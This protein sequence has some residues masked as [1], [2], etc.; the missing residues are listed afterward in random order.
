MCWADYWNLTFPTSEMAGRGQWKSIWYGVMQAS[1]AGGAIALGLLSQNATVIVGVAITS[2]FMPPITNTG[3]L[4]AWVCHISWRGLGQDYQAY[5]YTG[6]IYM[7]KPA[8]APYQGYTPLYYPDMRWECMYMSYISAIYTYVNV[9]CLPLW[10]AIV[11]KMKEIV[12]LGNLEPNKR[13]F[14]ED[15]RTY[16]EYHAEHRRSMAVGTNDTVGEQILR[17]WAV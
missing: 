3:I 8:W 11:L 2:T 15:L 7:M 5:N 13:F 16:R 14:Q 6:T 12:P 10:C 4:W 9:I 1:W 17:E